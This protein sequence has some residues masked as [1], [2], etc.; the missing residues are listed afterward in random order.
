MPRPTSF[1]TNPL[2][3]LIVARL[4]EA[5]PESPDV[6]DEEMA[7]ITGLSL[8]DF[9]QWRTLVDQARKKLYRQ[10]E[11]LFIRPRGQKM[12]R[13]ANPSEWVSA[14]MGTAEK[15]HRASLRGARMAVKVDRRNVTD[16]E[17]RQLDVSASCLAAIAH[18]T[19]PSVVRRVEAAVSEGNRPLPIGRV[20]EICR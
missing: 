1:A 15:V 16:S 9:N 4:R 5:T 12:C 8:A 19:K 14:V 3:S 17:R 20:L 18:A 6:P 2:I 10:E 13:L 7:R 11:K